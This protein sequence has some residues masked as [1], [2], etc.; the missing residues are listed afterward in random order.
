MSGVLVVIELAQDRPAAVSLELLGLGQGIAQQTGGAVSALVFSGD[1]A[2]AAA[3]IARGAERVFTV[4]DAAAA[5]YN[6]DTWLAYAERAASV[7]NASLV[8]A[9]HTTKGADLA[10]RLAF[11]L[12]SAVATGCVAVAAEGGVLRFTRP[13]YGGNARETVSFKTL[14]AVATVRGGVCDA[15]PE[16]RARRGEITALGGDAPVSR[17]RVVERHRDSG[18]QARLEDARVIVAGGRGLN[19]PEGFQVLGEL[20]GAL[21]GI[22]GASRVPCDLGWC[23][24]SMQIGLTGKTV[25]PD[26]YVAVGISGASH[27]MAGCGS[28][29]N[30]VAINTDP[31]AAIF[32][33]AR[34]GVIGDFQKIVPALAAEVRKLMAERP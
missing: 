24:H 8:L 20:A 22:V 6:S 16:D 11:R 7:A 2:I 28:A 19:G 27:H 32:R 30:I 5:E 17:I 31:E 14:P 9:G 3:L 12:K 34:F 18:G 33:D 21:G 13:C 25:T 4:G 23:P 10:P 15:V 26:L 29:R 1:P